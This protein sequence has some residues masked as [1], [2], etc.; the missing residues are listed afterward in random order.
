[1]SHELDE[2]STKFVSFV[3][4]FV[5]TGQKGVSKAGFEFKKG[6][7]NATRMQILLYFCIYECFII[8]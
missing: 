8:Q 2:F 1:M 7:K 3:A 6:I 5:K 4:H